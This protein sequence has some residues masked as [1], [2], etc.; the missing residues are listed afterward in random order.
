MGVVVFIGNELLRCTDNGKMNPHFGKARVE[1]VSDKRIG[2]VLA[3]PGQEKIHA[4][5]SRNGQMKCVAARD[6]RQDAAAN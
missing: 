6:G 3:V 5:N 1:A 4:V 2:D